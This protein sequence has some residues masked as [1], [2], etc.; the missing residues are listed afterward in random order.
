[1]RELADIL[2]ALA[3]LPDGND[4]A[5]ATVVRVTGS[6]YR[7]PGARL[8]IG[9]DG[10]RIG[11]VSGG[12]LERDVIQRA[13]YIIAS[14]QPILVRYETANDP[15]N[16]RGFSLGCGGTIDIL[17]EPLN[18]PSGQELIQWLKTSRSTRCVIATS[19]SRGHSA[20]PLGSRVMIDASGQIAGSMGIASDLLRHKASEVLA[21]D[22]SMV[23]SL[24][25]PQGN[26]DL[27]FELL[28]PPTELLIFGA[29]ADATPLVAIGRLL[30]WT[31]TV[32][33]L[34]SS[35]PDPARVWSPDRIIRCN[36]DQVPRHITIGSETAAVVMT[37][38]F[39][40]DQKLLR[41]LAALPLRYLGMLGPRH[42]TDQLLGD[43]Q[44]ESLR[45]PVGLDIGAESPEEVA[46]SIAAEITAALR[47]GSCKPLSARPGPIHIRGNVD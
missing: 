25:T 7:A 44:I 24:P 3:E 36:A 12:C 34:A 47:G 19:L 33:D 13:G 4:A 1:M 10:V 26:L 5:L 45:A 40:H 38:N 6:A 9:A 14:G 15:E 29:G 8:L 17:I 31:V 30:G 16:G 37:H 27:F 42:R 35:A 22:L 20:I 2:R 23:A 46:L 28:K 41:W 32:V 21:A 11:Q 39:D 18:T 43:L